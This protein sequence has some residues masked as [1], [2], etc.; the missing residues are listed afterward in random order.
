MIIIPDTIKNVFICFAEH[1][2]YAQYMY[3]QGERVPG[4]YFIII[5]AVYIFILVVV[6]IGILYRERTHA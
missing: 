1:I 2:I 6:C 3:K 4:K 5:R